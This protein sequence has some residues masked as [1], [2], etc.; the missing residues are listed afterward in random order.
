MRWVPDCL[1]LPSTSFQASGKRA[2][3]L[4]GTLHPPS[5]NPGAKQMGVRDPANMLRSTERTLKRLPTKLGT[6]L[7]PTLPAEEHVGQHRRDDHQHDRQ[8]IAE[9]PIKFR[10]VLEVH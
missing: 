6:T 5:R 2:V 3:C 10:H 1:A 4:A 7:K 9:R 8:R